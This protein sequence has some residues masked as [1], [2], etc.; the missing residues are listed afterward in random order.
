MASQAFVL[1]LK[2][3]ALEEYTRR[4][5]SIATEWPD[6]QLA[7]SESGV[8]MLRIYAND[9]LLFLY[10]EVDDPGAFP[11]LWATPVHKRWA[12]VMD[13]LIELDDAG[14]PDARFLHEAYEF[15]G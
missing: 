7:L 11:R 13:P 2:P 6:L 10:A 4:H 5:G 8:R 15:H 9:P 14:R 12:L 3:G 1:R